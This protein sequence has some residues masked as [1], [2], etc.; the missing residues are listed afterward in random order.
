[1][2]CFKTTFVFKI[3]IQALLVA[4]C[5]TL[6]Y[7]NYVLYVEKSEV[8]KQIDVLVNKILGNKD[9]YKFMNDTKM[10]K[11]ISRGI[12]ESI[13]E[14]EM[15]ALED[16]VISANKNNA[17]IKKESTIVGAIVVLLI[18]VT[19]IVFYFGFKCVE[20]STQVRDIVIIIS[21]VILT[22]F[23]FLNLISKNYVFANPNHIVQT[24]FQTISENIK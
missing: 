16:S 5:L 21:F 17:E 19:L 2:N 6:F 23:V 13:K 3:I 15:I 4:I 18:I 11:I 10:N 7:Y 8:T 1:M 12:L 24:I 9:R 22:E 14:D 20:I